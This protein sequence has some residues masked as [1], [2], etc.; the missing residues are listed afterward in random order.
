MSR[1]TN[2]H[3][4]MHWAAFS[5]IAALYFTVVSAQSYLVFL[6]NLYM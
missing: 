3:E 4:I 2:V 6:D 5:Y 1:R